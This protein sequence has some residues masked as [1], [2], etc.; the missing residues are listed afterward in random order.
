MTRKL[1]LIKNGN[2]I[3]G[4]GQPSYKSD[5]LISEDKITEIGKFNKLDDVDIKWKKE[6]LIAREYQK[7]LIKW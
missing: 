3:D 7:K 5:I 1:I 4:T 6:V 2:V